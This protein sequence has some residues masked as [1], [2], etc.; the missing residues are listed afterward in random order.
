MSYVPITPFGRALSGEVIEQHRQ[1]CDPLPETAVNKYDVLRNLTAARHEFNLSDR[2]L[3]VLQTLLSFHPGKELVTDRKPLTVFPSNKSICERLNG[4]A[5]STMRRHLAALVSA[6]LIL[7]RD[8]PNGKRYVKRHQAFGFD[9]TP[10]VTRFEEIETLATKARKA[11]E[12]MDHLRCAVSLMRRDLAG[13]AEYGAQVH[14]ERRIWDAFKDGALLAARDLRRKLSMEE[15][16]DLKETLKKLLSR[17]KAEFQ[18]EDTAE[19]ITSDAETEQ[20]HH[21][22]NIDKYRASTKAKQ[23]IDV[24]DCLEKDEPNVPLEMVLGSCREVNNYSQR[25]LRNW[26]DLVEAIQVIRPMMGVSQTVWE[27]AI[28]IMGQRNASV[29]LACMLERFSEIETPNGYLKTLT[30][31]ARIGKFSSGPMVLALARKEAA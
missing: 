12:E 15:L 6:G 18:I 3:S 10:L 30:R 16:Q 22:S 31:K 19:M 14:P 23:T 17:A 20:H 4:M 25:P 5:C 28:E 21:N 7:R 27:D 11:L 8:S 29:V 26:A 9:L 2:T 13:L 1:A 24:L